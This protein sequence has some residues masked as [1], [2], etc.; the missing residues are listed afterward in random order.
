MKKIIQ[1]FFYDKEILNVDVDSEKLSKIH[2]SIIKKKTLLRSAFQTFYEDMSKI[3][4]RFFCKNGLEIELG[5]G[6]GFFKNFRKQVITSDI[7][8]GLKYDMIIDAT[9][10]NLE[11]NSVKCIFAINVFHHISYP[12]KFFKEL[13]RVLKKDG[14]C[15]LIEPHNGFISKLLHKNMHKDEYF[16]TEEVNWDKEKSSG[17]LSDANQALS[18]NVF[19]RDKSIFQ[20]KYG[21]NLEIIHKQYEIN[22]LRY[23]FSGGL[24]F[25]QILPSFFLPFLFFLEK[26]FQPLAKLW[27]PYQMIVIKK[28]R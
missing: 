14:G 23:I 25:K 13:I 10:M 4:D 16:E 22:G 7:R 27:V 20:Q 1:K 19:E 28:I 21:P 24:N 18:Y 15:I 3:C 6:V 9:D 17:I 8:P 12:N 11:D 26:F 2:S 5:S